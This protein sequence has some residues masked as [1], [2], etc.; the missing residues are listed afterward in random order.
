VTATDIIIPIFN[1]LDD[2]R[3]CLTWLARNT[4]TPYRLILIDN[5][6]D[7]PTARWLA[8]AARTEKFGPTL[9]IRNEDNRG[10]C[11]ATNQ[12]LEA[13]TAEF[14][15]LLNNDTL[16]GPGWLG[17]ILAHFQSI[18]VLAMMSP[19]GDES[20]EN[21][22][23]ASRIEDF[24][25][26][27]AR[28][29]DKKWRELDHCSGF[30]L[31]MPRRVFAELGPFDDTYTAGNWAD[32]DYARRAQARGWLCGEAKDAFVFHLGHRTFDDVDQAWR[33][34]SSQNQAAFYA[35]WGRPRR[36]FLAPAHRLDAATDQARDEGKALF[37]LARQ[38]HRLWVPLLRRERVETI[39][40]NLDRPEHANVTFL[41]SPLPWPLSL[42]WA[43]W[44]WRYLK[45][46]GRVEVRQRG[47]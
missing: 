29:C 44:K 33:E 39:L 20:S 13:A 22:R 16:P 41:E 2:T 24:A 38:G 25:R 47:A 9:L 7:E 1:R 42:A 45:G 8:E 36:I 46:K 12:G 14:V 37:D 19:R 15:C 17:R 43:A 4:D 26:Q 35:R 18:P 10:W 6:S 27:I 3:E 34:Q 32:N 31:L 21:R 23:V 40:K 11:G 28:D 30:C 5:R